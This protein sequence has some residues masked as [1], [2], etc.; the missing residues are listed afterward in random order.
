M[1]A[2]EIYEALSEEEKTAVLADQARYTRA[3]HAM[4]TGVAHGI[5][6]GIAV[7]HTAKHLR[8]GVNSSMVE[9]AALTELL[10]EKGIVTWPEYF[11]SLADKM[12]QEVAAYERRYGVRFL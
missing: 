1:N 5:E 4:Q 6:T 9:H 12:E 8:T 11:K 3:C 10:V 7:D 2:K